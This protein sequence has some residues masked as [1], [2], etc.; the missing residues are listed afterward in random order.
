MTLILF[1][2]KRKICKEESRKK[3]VVSDHWSIAASTGSFPTGWKSEVLGSLGITCL[4]SEFFECSKE[5]KG[6]TQLDQSPTQMTGN[7]CLTVTLLLMKLFKN[8]LKCNVRTV[9]KYFS[10]VVRGIFIIDIFLVS[11]QRNFSLK[12]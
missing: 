1:Y 5:P 8:M 2:G 12:S 9:L 4:S 10:Q 6:K 11:L 3:A 7:K